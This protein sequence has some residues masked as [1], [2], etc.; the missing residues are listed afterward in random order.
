MSSGVTVHQDCLTVFQQLKLGK[1]FKY[2]IF[3]LNKAKT[4]I[5]KEKESNRT[6]LPEDQ[7]RWAV[8]DLEFEKE[9]GGKRNKIT[10]FSWTP[11][12]AKVKDKM[13]A[14][15][16]RD[17]LRRALVG[18]ALDIQ[19]TDDSEVAYETVLD[20]AKRGN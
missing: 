9:D 1:K 3:N 20:K 5:I 2:I 16:S 7:C 19:G 18:I 8:Y 4:E 15:S 14:A 17:A 13:V 10:F 6:N 12:G 11:D